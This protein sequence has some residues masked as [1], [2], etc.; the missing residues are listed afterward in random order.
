MLSDEQIELVEGPGG[1]VL[2]P[3]G[4][5]LAR[6]IVMKGDYMHPAIRQGQV[7]VLE[8][9]ITPT[10]GEYVL[11]VLNNGRHLV[12]ELLMRDEETVTVMIVNG[13]KRMTF[14]RNEIDE[15]IAIGAQLPSSR[16]VKG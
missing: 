16:I 9:G 13:T 7:L 6:A 15:L 10:P 8:P 2:A 5:G 12:V 11:L 4:D 14:D 1:Y 3:T